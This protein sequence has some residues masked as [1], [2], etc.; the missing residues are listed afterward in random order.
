MT[1]R[2]TNAFGLKNST[3]NEIRFKL[4]LIFEEE[5]S[6]NLKRRCSS[7]YPKLNLIW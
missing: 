5:F 3:F 2:A 7:M 1:Q 6:C 4:K